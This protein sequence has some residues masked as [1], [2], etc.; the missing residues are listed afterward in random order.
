VTL[1]RWEG[2]QEEVVVV[3]AWND[4]STTPVEAG[5]L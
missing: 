3:T 2:V 4:G 1:V 5:S